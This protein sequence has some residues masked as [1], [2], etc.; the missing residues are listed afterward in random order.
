MSDNVISFNALLNRPLVVNSPDY[1]CFEQPLSERIRTFLRLEFLFR[2][3]DFHLE[4]P[5]RW[6]RRATVHT[7]LDTLILLSRS[8]IKTDVIKELSEQH[9]T[10]SRLERRRG[11]DSDRLGQVLD[12]LEQVLDAMHGQSAQSAGTILK[13]NE[14]LN[15]ILHRSAIPGGTCGFDLPGYEHWLGQ[16][17]EFQARDLL[18]WT[19]DLKPFKD[20]IRL[21]LRLIRQSEQPVETFAE[22]G[23]YI[24]TLENPCQMVRVLT[25]TPSE[26]F[27][28]ISAGKHRFTI[29]FMERHSANE[30]AVPT[31]QDVTFR[32]ACC[33]I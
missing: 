25:A 1:L 31:T 17:E 12:N 27:P 3:V 29:R 5:N 4:D 20:A 32:L 18:S 23:V 8:D 6:S 7:L 14:F 11:V 22:G 21:L 2:Q 26:L 28:E 33:V 30:R 13:S 10:L 15:G 9:L 16:P 24:H 19:E